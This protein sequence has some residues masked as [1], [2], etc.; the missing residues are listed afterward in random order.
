MKEIPAEI[1]VLYDALLVQ[2]KIPEK[3]RF[4][5]TKWL[6]YYLDFCHKYGFSESNPQSLPKFVRKVA[7]VYSGGTSPLKRTHPHWVTI[8]NFIPIYVESQG[9]GFTLARA[10]PCWVIFFRRVSFTHALRLFPFFSA[11]MA[12]V[13]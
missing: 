12:I 4:Y 7:N 5:Y 3:S 6:R 13:L 2:K 10:C 9:F 11:W 8:T 1:R